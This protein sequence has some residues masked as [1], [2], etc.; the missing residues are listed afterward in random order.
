MGRHL[1]CA[2]TEAGLGGQHGGPC[3]AVTAGNDEGVAHIA[4]VGVGAPFEEQGADV[5]LLDEGVVG[6]YLLDALLAE[7]DVEHL[8]L[9]DVLLVLREE[10]GE[11]LLLEGE[12][13][14]GADDVGAD[15]IGVVLR[16]QP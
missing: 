14:I 5:V 16:H 6:F 11:F 7:S 4:L 15:V 9:S 2:S 13:H 12:R 8:Q 1:P 3:H 10:E